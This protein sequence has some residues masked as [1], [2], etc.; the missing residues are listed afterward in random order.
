[1]NHSEMPDNK[2]ERVFIFA[3]NDLAELLETG[4]I[5]TVLMLKTIT[6]AV[7]HCPDGEKDD[8]LTALSVLQARKAENGYYMN[9]K[10]VL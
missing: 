10:G 9:H 7:R 3:V 6:Q 2:A 8:L 1:M 5:D 4:Q